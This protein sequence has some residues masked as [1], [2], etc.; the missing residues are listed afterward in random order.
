MLE[1]ELKSILKLSIQRAL[2]GEIYREIRAVSFDND[3][4]KKLKLIYYLDRKPVDT[5]YES[6]SS[7]SAE[8]LADVKFKEIEEVCKFIETPLSDLK[9][10]NLVY[11]R[12]E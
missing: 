7:V 11:L 8:V 12:K 10:E 6:L 4:L 9:N 3:G 2:L 1:T 5:D